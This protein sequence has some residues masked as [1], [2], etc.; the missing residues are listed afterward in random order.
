MGDE[1]SGSDVEVDNDSVFSDTKAEMTKS[2]TVIPMA[3]PV[4]VDPNWSNIDSSKTMPL[5]GAQVPLPS[6]LGKIYPIHLSNSISNLR[7]FSN[8]PN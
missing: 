8:Q 6:S 5:A 2:A 4:Q 1:K 7:S 3:V